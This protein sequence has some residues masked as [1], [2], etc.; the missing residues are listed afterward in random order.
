MRDGRQI[1]VAGAGAVGS[2]AAYALARAGGRVVVVDPG[3]PN[4]SAVAAGMLAPAFEALFD[5]ISAERFGLFVEARDR[6]PALAQAIGLALARDGAMAVGARVDVEAWAARLAGIGARRQVLGPSEAAQLAPGLAPDAWAVFTP[7][8][9]R[10]DGGQ[11]LAA[12]RAAAE[13]LGARFVSGSVAGFAGGRVRLADGSSLEAGTLVV[14]TGAARSLAATAPELNHLT[15]VKGHILRAAAPWP[16]GPVLRTGDVYLCRTS[17]GLV[18]GATMEAG[19]DD[20]AVDPG[21]VAS[22]VA[23]GERLS[24]GLGGLPW[25][26]TT[27]VR[28]AT[29]DGLPMVGASRTVGA[30]I[31]VGARRNGWLLAPLIAEAILDI[32]EGG[33]PPAPFDP[34]RLLA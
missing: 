34:R 9:W 6:W 7:E 17:G 19:L 14:A 1:V 21:L 23:R 30:I 24:A 15:P 12:L 10:L 29:R 32:V 25:R 4:A 16:G 2:A 33:E 31:A 8:D 3:A 22:L 11:A 18:L 27:G 5:A 20:D 26:A 28:A 13:A